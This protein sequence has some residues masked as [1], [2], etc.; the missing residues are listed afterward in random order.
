MDTSPP[1]ISSSDQIAQVLRNQ[2][3]QG[4]LKSGQPLRQDEIAARF[5]VSKIPVREALVR[6]KAEGL[7]TFYPNRGAVVSELSASEADEI[8]IMRV[9][10]E[11]AVLARAIPRLTIA[12]LQQAEDLLSALDQE[13]DPARWSMLNWSFHKVLYGPA[14]MPRLLDTLHTLHV[15]VARYLVLYLAEM[16]YQ[17]TSQQEHR[18]ILDACRFG[19]IEQAV[20]RLEIHLQGAA[21]QLRA[22]LSQT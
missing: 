12:N 10:L 5:G 4:K 21:R 8:Y 6:L 9:A 18:D 3:L 7:V 1:A 13:A 2:I 17:S 14:G 20:A 11:T 16:D 15:N 22:F 19:N